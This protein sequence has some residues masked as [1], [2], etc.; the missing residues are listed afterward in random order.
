MRTRI[1]TLLFIMVSMLDIFFTIKLLHQ[2]YIMDYSQTGTHIE[3]FNIA[4][5]EVNPL[6]SK[7]ILVYG[8]D[9]M[10]VYKLAILTIFCIMLFTIHKK[11]TRLSLIISTIGLTLTTAIVIYGT[12]GLILLHCY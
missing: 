7:I 8:I 4:S 3:D 6:A 10:V 12:V 11:S 9:G 2:I 1:I 5:F